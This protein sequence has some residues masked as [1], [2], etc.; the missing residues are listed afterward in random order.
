MLRVHFV[1]V[2]VFQLEYMLY[3]AGEKKTLIIITEIRQEVSVRT[4]QSWHV[5]VVS[6]SDQLIEFDILSLALFSVLQ[7]DE[8]KWSNSLFTHVKHY[9]ECS[10]ILMHQQSIFS[11]GLQAHRT[12]FSH[13][14][15]FS[16]Y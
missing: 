4:V 14:I 3:R 2:C 8:Y 10:F 11:F 16:Q 13:N 7:T 9:F 12:P 6:N 1:S 15:T 5:L